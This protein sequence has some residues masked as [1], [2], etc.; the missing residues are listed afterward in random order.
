MKS[1]ASFFPT[2]VREALATLTE[3]EIKEVVRPISRDIISSMETFPAVVAKRT[4][5]KEIEE[6]AAKA[7]KKEAE[8]RENWNT[9][10]S[11][12]VNGLKQFGN[13]LLT[14][15]GGMA[16]YNSAIGSAGDAAMSIGKS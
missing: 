7:A 12:A 15:S 6:A 8:W 11:Q 5:I 3:Q 10:G 14:A 1:K 4:A 16:K 9:A 2:E 13:S